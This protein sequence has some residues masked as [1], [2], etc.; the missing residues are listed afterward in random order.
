MD[1]TLGETCAPAGEPWVNLERICGEPWGTYLLIGI[2]WMVVVVGDDCGQGTL[3]EAR[4]MIFF[5]D[6]LRA[7]VRAE[8][9]VLQALREP[10]IHLL[11]NAVDHGIESPALRAERGKPE[12]GRILL[13]ARHHAGMLVLELRDDGAGVDLER[14]RI[15]SEDSEALDAEFFGP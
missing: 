15:A 7:E 9:R 2:G 1:V 8:R 5:E 3:G 11:R 4:S 12:E 13:R 14:L 6:T 10:I